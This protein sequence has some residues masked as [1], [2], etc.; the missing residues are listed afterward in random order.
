MNEYEKTIALVAAQVFTA[1]DSEYSKDEAIEAAF[2]ICD[3]VI[4]ENDRRSREGE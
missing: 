2:Y 4:K 1:V 3:E